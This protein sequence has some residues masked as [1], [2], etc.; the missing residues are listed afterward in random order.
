M[1]WT[2]W[3]L[4]E[5]L[6]EFAEIIRVFTFHCKPRRCISL[7]NEV[8]GVPFRSPGR[9]ILPV[10]VLDTDQLRDAHADAV[11]TQVPRL[12]A[13]LGRVLPPLRRAHLRAE[14]RVEG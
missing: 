11:V 13:R 6:C 1:M 12:V 8:V 3:A 5:R 14:F 2:P 4:S 10:D 9:R 7:A